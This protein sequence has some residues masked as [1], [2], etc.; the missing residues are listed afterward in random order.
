[1]GRDEE[2]PTSLVCYIASSPQ[3]DAI[4]SYYYAILS[5]YVVSGS[6]TEV[7]FHLFLPHNIVWSLLV[8]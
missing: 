1:M 8:N 7:H 6:L 4:I 2:I 5:D 3:Y